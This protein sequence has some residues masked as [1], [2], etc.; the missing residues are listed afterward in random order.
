[1]LRRLFQVLGYVAAVFVALA[2][3]ILFWLDHAFQPSKDEVSSV[4]SPD[5]RLVASLIEVNGGATTSFGY[6]VHLAE[7][8]LLGNS[9]QV[10]S[11]YGAV[12]N[13]SAYGANLRWTGKNE[14]SVEF[15]DAKATEL[16]NSRPRFAGREVLVVLRPNIRDEA[17]PAGGM[18]H[19]SQ[20][21]HQ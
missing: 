6:S 8:G 9:Q 15:L 12:R 20:G 18:L 13:D 11:L 5:G 1:M 17:A 19:N 21:K 14:L 4:A 3:A 16:L 10:A 7:S 2:A